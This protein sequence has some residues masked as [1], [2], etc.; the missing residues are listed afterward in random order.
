MINNQNK[1]V[2]AENAHF[3]AARQAQIEEAIE[4]PMKRR[5]DEIQ[6]G[7]ILSLDNAISC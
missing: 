5:F 1:P 4:Y 6:V 7:Y 3:Y 2:S